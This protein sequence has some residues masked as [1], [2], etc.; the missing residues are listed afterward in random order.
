MEAART[1]PLKAA[2]EGPPG[3]S[4]HFQRNAVHPAGRRK[5]RLSVL[6]CRAVEGRGGQ[7][8]AADGE[9]PL[10]VRP[11]TVELARVCH[12]KSAPAQLPE[13]DAK[14]GRRTVL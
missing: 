1:E 3:S 10:L 4:G 9:A 5:K 8:S 2:N 7:S 14:S 6:M 11:K 12:E 13:A